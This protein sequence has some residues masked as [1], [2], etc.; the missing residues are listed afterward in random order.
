MT[1]RVARTGAGI[2]VL[3]ASVAV[4]A[5][6]GLVCVQI[7]HAIGLFAVVVIAPIGAAWL[8]I[9]SP[10]VAVAVRLLAPEL[11]EHGSRRHRAERRRAGQ[12]LWVAPGTARAPFRTATLARGT[13][14]TDRYGLRGW[15]FVAVALL[16]VAATVATWQVAV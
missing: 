1:R 7:W 10:L 6:P 11:A 14:F 15:A 2:V 4:L 9:V 8:L 12:R 3:G 5:L 16:A 13:R